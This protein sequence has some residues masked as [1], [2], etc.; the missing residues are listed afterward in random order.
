MKVFGMIAPG[1]KIH[2]P[3]AKEEIVNHL[4]NVEISDSEIYLKKIFYNNIGLNA[5]IVIGAFSLLIFSM[6]ILSFNAIQIGFLVKGLYGAYGLRLAL[7]LVFPHLFIELIS[8]LLSLY[9]SFL[10]L[11]NIIM[12]LIMREDLLKIKM[13]IYP[14]IVMLFLVI[15][16]VTY[17]GAV[18]EVFVTPSLI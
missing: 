1:V 18:I 8:H 3:D 6:I 13:E 14:R 2:V 10:I 12:P 9:L 5:L 17:L 15:I 16:L 7:M 11:V 4:G